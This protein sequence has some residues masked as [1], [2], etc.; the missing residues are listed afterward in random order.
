MSIALPSNNNELNAL[1][2]KKTELQAQLA[3]LAN[4]EKN[5]I[6]AIK[7]KRWWTISDKK[8]IMFD[9]HTGYFWP[10]PQY[11]CDN[12]KYNLEAAEKACQQL[13]LGQQRNW[14]LPSLEDAALIHKESVLTKGIDNDCLTTSTTTHQAHLAH[15]ANIFAG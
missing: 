14:K 15:L 10:N 1:Q 2:T 7:Q 6:D 13:N 5:L 8:E 11:F 4:D 3:A 9:S 12:K